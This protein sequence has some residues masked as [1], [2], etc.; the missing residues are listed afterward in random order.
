MVS[1]EI[2][3]EDSPI[4]TLN[5]EICGIIAKH[6]LTNCHKISKNANYSTP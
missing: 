5:T 2:S 3:K 6:L 4:D 1:K